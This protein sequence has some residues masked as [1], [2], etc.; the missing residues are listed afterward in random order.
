MLYSRNDIEKHSFNSV[1]HMVLE[2]DDLLKEVFL[3]R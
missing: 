3:K 1:F 2:L